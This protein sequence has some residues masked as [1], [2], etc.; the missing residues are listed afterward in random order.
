MRF[1]LGLFL[2]GCV[3]PGPLKKDHDELGRILSNISTD[4]A[5]ECAPQ[6]YAQAQS[7]HVFAGLELQQADTRRA[8]E[9]LEE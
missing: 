7:E 6:E 4:M 1:L 8:R 9:H 5:L 2:V 3:S